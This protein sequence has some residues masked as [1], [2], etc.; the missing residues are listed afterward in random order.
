VY[1]VA[2]VFNA[3]FR[4]AWM[5]TILPTGLS[6]KTEDMTFLQMVSAHAG[7]L[8]ASAEV[9]R[10][11]VWGWLRMEYEHIELF[12][13]PEKVSSALPSPGPKISYDSSTKSFTMV[14]ADLEAFDK[15][16]YY[17]LCCYYC[18]YNLYVNDNTDLLATYAIFYYIL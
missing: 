4:F 10:R 17:C 3:F 16:R 1:T 6:G 12:G 13:Q 7:P 15:V 2:A 14:G 9:V 18:R 5:L 8:V 11:M